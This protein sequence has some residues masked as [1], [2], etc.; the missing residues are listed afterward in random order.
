[1]IRLTKIIDSP[2][3]TLFLL[4]LFFY[5]SIT[6]GN[7]WESDSQ[8]MYQTAKNLIDH[9]SFAVDCFWEAA[10]SGNVCYSKYGL[11]SSLIIIPMYLLEK[12][13]LDVFHNTYFYAG[14]FPSLT[15]CF[16]TS[17]LVVLT[18]KYLIKLKFSE[19]YAIMGAL[20]LGFGTYLSAYT[21]TLFSEPLTTLLFYSAS[22]VFIFW[23]QTPKN[24]ALAGF[25]FGFTFLTKFG[26][27][28]FLPCLIY[29]FISKKINLKHF[30]YFIIP[31][32]FC[33]IIYFIYN[34]LRFGD[35]FDSGYRDI[36]TFGFPFF[37]GLYINLLSPGKSLFLYQPIIFFAFLGIK[38]LKKW[39]PFLLGFFTIMTLINF[40]FFSFFQSP[41]GDLAWGTRYLYTS[42]P[43][44]II[45]LMYFLKSYKERSWRVIFIS[46][47]LVSLII[48]FS[49]I[50]ISYHRYISYIQKKLGIYDIYPI[51]QLSPLYG[52]WKIIFRLNYMD[53]DRKYWREAF[54][55][56]INFDLNYRISPPDIFLLRTKQGILVFLLFTLLEL[57]FLKKLYAMSHL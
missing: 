10:K 33:V 56:Y 42:L 16:I 8:S 29:V 11:I 38:K 39:N 55:E 45:L 48:Q 50:Y 22:Y 44:F 17:L 7:F 35:I 34:Y 52:Q 15:N 27:L 4:F 20:L 6:G 28:I 21:K 31:L 49:S 19:K 32:F 41:T 43:F 57:Y 54:Q 24:L 1:M 25:L 36:K 3:L 5:I 26:I 53:E 40:T 47:F 12:L 46:V 23:K 51:A 2:P 9:Q 30:L 14:F 37:Y 13:F 18:Y